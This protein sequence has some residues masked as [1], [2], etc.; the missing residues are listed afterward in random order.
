[1]SDSRDALSTAS[2]TQ[3]AS[4]AREEWEDWMKWDGPLDSLSASTPHR[5]PP[6]LQYVSGSLGSTSPSDFDSLPPINFSPVYSLPSTES[7]KRKSSAIAGTGNAPP[8]GSG[9]QPRGKK[10]SHNVIEKRYRSNLNDKIAKLRDSV[11]ELRFA[12]PT[13]KKRPQKSINSD[14]DGSGDEAS[15][16]LKFNK[17][18]VLIKATEYIQQLE[19]Q[20]Q[21]LLA[22]VSTLRNRK[23]SKGLLRTP[24]VVSSAVPTIFMNS[25]IA[26]THV[27][28][29]P[30]GESGKGKN[31]ITQEPSPAG[32]I[33]VPE[34]VRRL[35]EEAT[36]QGHY[37]PE[38]SSSGVDAMMVI[39]PWSEVQGMV[40]VSDSW[41]RFRAQTRSEEHYAPISLPHQIPE[42]EESVLDNEEEGSR[43]SRSR[44]M[45]R[46]LVGS[47]AGLMIMEGFTEREEVSPKLNKRG[48]FSLPNELLTESRGFRE[49]IRRRIIA[50]AASGRS[51]QALPILAFSFV[52]LSLCFAIFVYSI[53]D[54][55]KAIREGPTEERRT[56]VDSRSSDSL[57]MQGAAG[58]S[59]PTPAHHQQILET[60]N[61]GEL[62]ALQIIRWL[63]LSW[64]ISHDH[65]EEAASRSDSRSLGRRERWLTYLRVPKFGEDLRTN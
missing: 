36:P 34:D 20:N 4:F 64:L 17:A 38:S 58:S 18:T 44:M 65:D 29:T 39:P 37:A 32:M 11:P 19:R 28:E 15:Q 31:G 35:R 46:M 55:S 42:L 10:I 59:H 54:G 41:R 26:A 1:M 23:G 49:P 14:S 51:Q 12:P 40:P 45:S 22:E 7:K 43:W 3:P 63:G 8:T 52:F 53:P 9:R 57:S 2:T 5:S 33:K 47:L 27:E 16:G 25:A 56:S 62:Y 50:F 30:R 48:L 21:R 24:P 6:P 61:F 60:S 13:I